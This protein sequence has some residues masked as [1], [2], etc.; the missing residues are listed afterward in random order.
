MEINEL[1][2]EP[3]QYLFKKDIK[4]SVSSLDDFVDIKKLKNNNSDTS[5]LS[6]LLDFGKMK[7]SI[8]QDEDSK[9]FVYRKISYSTKS[10][11]KQFPNESELKRV[12]SLRKEISKIKYLLISIN[13]S[14]YFIQGYCYWL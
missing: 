7:L 12:A 3:K 5:K 1:N 2:Y 14:N 10:I 11:E 9:R 8:L 6:S 4:S 13:E